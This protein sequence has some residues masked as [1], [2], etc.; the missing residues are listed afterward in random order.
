MKLLVL[1]LSWPALFTASCWALAAQPDALDR[2]LNAELGRAKTQLKGEGYSGIYYAAAD[3]WDFEDTQAWSQS[4]APA[5]QTEQR[6]RIVLFDVRVGGRELDNHPLE[7]KLDYFGQSIPMTQDEPALRHAF[8]R[9]LDVAY[10]AASADYLRKKALRVQK[11][12]A[13]YDADD[14]APEPPHNR[15][16]PPSPAVDAASAVRAAAEAATSKLRGAPGVLFAVSNAQWS[17]AAKRRRDSEGAAVDTLEEHASV[18]LSAEGIA[19]DGMR[20]TVNREFLA[21]SLEGLPGPVALVAAGDSLRAE[22]DELLAASSTAPF[23]APALVDPQVA[24]ALTLSLA[25]RLTG[26][27]LRNPSGAQTFRGRLGGRVL[28]ETLSLADDPRPKSW[29]GTPLLGHY[30]YDSQGVPARR[31]SL[32][33]KGRLTGLLLSRYAAKGFPRSNGHARSV[34]GRIAVGA[35]ANLFLSASAPRRQ[36]E[37]LE[38]LRQQCRARGLPYGLWFRGVDSWSQEQG[39][40][41]Q[42]SIRVRTGVWLV[43]AETGA[44]TRVRDLDLVGTPL[45]M[46]GG[47]LDAG[48]DAAVWSN[49]VEGVVVSV[50]APSLL[51]ADAELQRAQ[52]Q[53]EKPPILPAP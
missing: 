5:A 35:P 43:S 38:R 3:V 47:I 14:L 23:N 9:L 19:P 25:L 2:A 7:P 4:G 1:A 44:L 36:A 31:A 41:G 13:D 33:E 37:L 34:P 20:Q 42:G 51:L 16:L 49:S 17:R 52:P 11:G 27:E 6:Q 18:T 15:R 29:N 12:K 45:A 39:G 10:K 28:P 48:D 8:W 24:G 53:P 32:I 40:G 22:L 26:E 50:V 21:R 30:E 46:L